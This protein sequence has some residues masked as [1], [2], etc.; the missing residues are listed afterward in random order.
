MKVFAVIIAGG[1]GERLWPL[2]TPEHPKQFVTL[3]G[4]KPLIRHAMDRIAGIVEP[5]EV[6]V[7]T[8]KPLVS[9][10]RKALPALPKANILAEPCRRNTAPAIALA[11]RE[12]KKRGGSDAVCCILT[13]DHLV[14][15]ESEF[16]QALRQAIAVAVK[17]RKIVTLG[18]RPTYAATGFGYIDIA[19]N[20]PR[21]T[22]K[23]DARKA[24]RFLKRGTYLWNSG[25]FIFRVDVMESELRAFAPDAAR[26]LDA[27]N[28]KAIYSSLESESIDYA[29]MEK[30]KE[31]AV[32]PAEFR[33]DDVGSWN[34]VPNR[35]E[36]D[37]DDNTCLGK[38][39]VYDTKG[40]VVVST[41]DHLAAVVG[42][43]DVVVVHTNKVTLVCA[44]SKAQDIKRLLAKAVLSLAVMFATVTFVYADRY[45]Y[46]RYQSI[47]ERQMFGPL[48][49]GFDPSKPPSEVQKSGSKSERELAQEQEKI[50]SAI[51]FS[52]IN[53]NPAGETVVGFTDSCDPKEVRHYYLKVGETQGG[54]TV[55]AADPLKATMT[56][57]KG[58][59]T[60][61]LGLGANSA[62]GAG[63]ASSNPAVPQTAAVGGGNQRPRSLLNGSGAVPV[64]GGSM[65][66]SLRAMQA[67]RRKRREAD[68]ADAA[69]KE[70]AAAEAKAKEAEDK[71]LA[72]ENIAQMKKQLNEL[73]E[74]NRLARE[75]KARKDSETKAAA[76]QDSAQD[77]EAQE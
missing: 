38:T 71:A 62:Q 15:P 33:W 10:T 24:A 49:N 31:L 29:V 40:S 5:S 72:E 73:V 64:A 45:P 14:D 25:M 69:A 75:E 66:G 60:L 12:V 56:I 54:W 50:K 34:S 68:A 27:G 41:P 57:V 7:V 2:S 74:A 63:N 28:W 67:E 18:I 23:P 3:F 65:F 17:E 59:V 53:V 6:L 61:D 20:P 19:A 22:E 1:S 11:V 43:K 35:F 46:E 37:A 76:E 58:D 16:R 39:A 32:V 30:T 47:V 77:S 55:K 44:K 9:Q 48:P 26:L 21:F 42:L 8:A 4:G 13:A 51:R 36:H 52:M 70:K